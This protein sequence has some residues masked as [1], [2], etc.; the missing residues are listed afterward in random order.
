M[1]NESRIKYQFNSCEQAIRDVLRGLFNQ[2]DFVRFARS[3]NPLII[4]TCKICDVSRSLDNF[5]VAN[6]QIQKNI[7]IVAKNC[8]MNCL[9]EQW[10]L[11]TNDKKL[12][13]KA[14]RVYI[15]EIINK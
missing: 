12:Y 15:S 4:K 11:K 2:S 9:L 7:K 14:E 13:E 8:L 3:I 1:I 5:I 10:D 6:P